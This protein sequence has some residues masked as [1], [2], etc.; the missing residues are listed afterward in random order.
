MRVFALGLVLLVGCSWDPP[1][2]RDG[3]EPGEVTGG[4]AGVAGTAIAGATSAIGEAGESGEA[5]AGGEEETATVGGSGGRTAGHAGKGG[6]GSVATGSSGAGG[7][8][9]GAGGLVSSGGS[10]MVTGGT[11]GTHSVAGAGGQTTSAGSGGF[12]EPASCAQTFQNKLYTCNDLYDGNKVC[13]NGA[14]V[15]CGVGQLD[16]NGDPAD[17]CEAY[18]GDPAH[19]GGCD[20]TSICRT[21]LGVKCTAASGKS[22]VCQ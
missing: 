12:V 21:D 7:A 18:A 13:L 10:P 19:C 1:K 2:G 9:G 16:C 15:E 6:A 22:F 11:G 17:G 5:G 14:C 4:S 20:K 8:S 3:Q